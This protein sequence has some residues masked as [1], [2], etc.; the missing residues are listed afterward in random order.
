MKTLRATMAIAA[1]A[2]AMLAAPVNAQVTT[3]NISSWLPPQHPVYADMLVPWCKDIEKDTQGKVRC[4]MLPKPVVVAMQTIDA[5]RDNLADV[6]FTVH[7][8]TAGRFPLAKAAEF[9]F[10]GD[11]AEATSVAWHRVY[12]RMLVQHEDYKGVLQLALFTH[13]P[14]Q[15]YNARRPVNAAKDMEGLKMR[16]GGGV[17]IDT[18]KALGMVPLVRPSTETYEMISGGIA[19]GAFLP[20][21][22][23]RSLKLESV[24]KYATSVPG[25]LYNSSFTLVMNQAKFNKLGNAEQ[26]VIM[27]HSGEAFSR[28]AGKA[29]DAA[30]VKGLETMKAAG[31]QVQTASD[32]LVKEIR[33]KTDPIEKE[34]IEKDAKPKGVDGA[35]VLA[36]LRAEIKNVAAG[37]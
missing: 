30:D 13:G 36:A 26:A 29:W 15:L 9:P 1:A 21:E 11:S 37:K 24:I 8:Y 14:G 17:V 5:V 22:T 25:G 4:N 27:K 34:W 23:V 16:I 10:L 35:K 32:A 31:I 33:A 28:R 3:L 12:N 2:G 7:G 18:A 19:D 6:S 20:K